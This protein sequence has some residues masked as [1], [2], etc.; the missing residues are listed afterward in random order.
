MMVPGNV[1]SPDGI[2]VEYSNTTLPVPLAQIVE[3]EYIVDVKVSE[4]DQGNSVACGAIGG[5][6]L[7]SSDLPF[8]IAPVNNSGHYGTGWLHDNGDGTTTLAVTATGALLPFTPIVWPV[9]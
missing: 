3:G 4:D 5:L 6:M 9:T 8:G 7:G 2:E 1:G